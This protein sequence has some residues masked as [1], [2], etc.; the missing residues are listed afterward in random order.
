MLIVT[1]LLL[2]IIIYC[3]LLFNK[4]KI[5]LFNFLLSKS[6]FFMYGLGALACGLVLLKLSLKTLQFQP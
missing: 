1:L 4:T 5:A 2:I 6:W 3:V